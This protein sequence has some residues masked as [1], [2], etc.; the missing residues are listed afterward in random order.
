LPDA[1]VFE[2]VAPGAIAGAPVVPLV[3]A[4]FIGAVPGSAAGVVAFWV[5][6]LEPLAGFD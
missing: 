4:A 5:A 6:I 2:A 3:P 1:P